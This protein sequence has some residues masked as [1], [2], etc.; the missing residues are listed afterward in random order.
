MP[1]LLRYRSASLG[2]CRWHQDNCVASH[3][4]LAP[5]SLPGRSDNPS[6]LWTE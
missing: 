5:L 4:S 1:R 3:A 6:N 2:Q